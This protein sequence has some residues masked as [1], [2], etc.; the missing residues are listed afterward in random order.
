MKLRT[1]MLATIAALAATAPAVARP[2]SLEGKWRL[3]VKESEFL[4]GEEPPAEL[5]MTITKDDGQAFHWTATIKLADGGSGATS[6]AGAID[7]KP[8]P[9]AGRPGST[10][11]FSW[12]P[13]GSLK[14][15]SQAAGGFAVEICTFPPDMKKMECNA[16]QTDTA[17]RAATYVELFERL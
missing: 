8:Y 10:S 1:I 4:A 3:N 17:G 14:Q 5:I 16:R 13:D 15:V 2:A 7:G 9:V 11:T 6:F 12:M